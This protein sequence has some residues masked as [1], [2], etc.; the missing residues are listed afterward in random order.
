MIIEIKNVFSYKGNLYK[1]KCTGYTMLGTEQWV[2]L[3]TEGESLLF[4][5]KD[6][7]LKHGFVLIRRGWFR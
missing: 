4:I 3:E 2:C 5:K 1:V 7:M 6:D